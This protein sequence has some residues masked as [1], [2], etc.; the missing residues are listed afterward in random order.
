MRKEKFDF[1]REKVKAENI[2]TVR[3]KTLQ[4]LRGEVFAAQPKKILEIG[5]AAGIS[6]AAMLLC[7]DEA[8]LVTIEKDPDFADRA[9]GIFRALG[10]EKRVTLLE[11][12]ADEIVPL[13][14]GGYDFIFLD[15]PK[16][17]YAAYLPDLKALLKPGGVL[18]ADNISLKFYGLKH[19]EHR[20]RTAHVNMAHFLET[21]RTDE[22]FSVRFFEEEDG[23]LIAEKLR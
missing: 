21:M 18:F 14:S 10:L 16:G 1:L 9:R 8:K 15:G 7:A 13:L 3:D 4:K 23:A 19:S 6:G 2:P 12:D 11:G 17:K 20:N 22:D 5:T